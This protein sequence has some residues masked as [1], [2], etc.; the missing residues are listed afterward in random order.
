LEQL[1]GLKTMFLALA[2]RTRFPMEQ[3]E[4]AVRLRWE[5][6][7]ARQLDRLWYWLGVR[8]ERVALQLDY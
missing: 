2:T 7:L 4:T 8:M 3:M 6:K 5:L 1:W